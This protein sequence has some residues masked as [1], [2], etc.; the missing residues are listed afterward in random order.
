MTLT[1]QHVGKNIYVESSE[2]IDVSN[3]RRR[4][5]QVKPREGQGELEEPTQR[6]YIP[7]LLCVS[8]GCRAND[9]ATA[10]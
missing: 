1:N 10:R 8:L 5:S 9:A 7:V 3:N 2:H 4:S 6:P